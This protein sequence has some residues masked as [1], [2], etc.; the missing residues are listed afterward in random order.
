[1]Q[2]VP[3]FDQTL[4]VL[5]AVAEST[6]LRL[7]FLCSHG[8]LTVTELTEA[9]GIEQPQVSRHLKI[10]CDAGVLERF[11]EGAWVFY[12]LGQGGGSSLARNLLNFVPSDD[13]SLVLD[14]RRMAR[15][16]REREQNAAKYFRENAGRWDE[17]RR[18]YVAEAEVENGLRKLFS[19]RRMRYF[20]DVGTG[21]GRMLEVFAPLCECAVGIDI[22]LEM[23]AVARVNLA[24]AG[25]ENC[26]VRRGD[27]YNLPQASESVDA[28]IF[29]QVLHYS[30]DPA[31][32][33][34]EA[35]RVLAPGG[36]IAVA[37]FASHQLEHLRS[38]HAHRRL[39]FRDRDVL[40]WFS[41]AGLDATE[42]LR[43]RGNPLTVVI[44]A[45]EKK[46]VT[47]GEDN[48]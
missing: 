36:I 13:A 20:L 28:V 44:W 1:M 39:G 14:R 3:S 4:A 29:H 30:D 32:A 8:E 26:R 12:S 34:M 40:A 27:M 10:L 37:D 24:R 35:A 23:L 5:R 25:I 6:R 11:R 22:S 17:L 2:L 45:A 16:R 7:V 9:L 33:I 18:L 38:E 19:S 31:M 15:I 47:S 42:S 21:T 43:L 41:D 46:A 48:K